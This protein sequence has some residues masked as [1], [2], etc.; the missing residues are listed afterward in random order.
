MNTKSS[1]RKFKKYHPYLPVIFTIIFKF[2]IRC[3]LNGS[4]YDSQFQVT[5][6]HSDHLIHSKEKQKDLYLSICSYV[7]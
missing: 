7:L 6:W 3:V 1:Q 5:F 4:Y 2:Y